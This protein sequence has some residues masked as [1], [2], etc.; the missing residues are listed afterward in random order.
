[1]DEDLLKR[2]KQQSTMAD[3]QRNSQQ[4]YTKTKSQEEGIAGENGP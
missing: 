4:V 2:V 3:R 1:M